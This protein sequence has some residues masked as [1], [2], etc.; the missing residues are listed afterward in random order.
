[1][2]EAGMIEVLVEEMSGCVN[3]KVSAEEKAG[4]VRS[5]GRRLGDLSN[6]QLAKVVDVWVDAQNDKTPAFKLPAVATLADIAKRITIGTRAS[7]ERSGPTPPR[8]EFVEAHRR[9]RL[10]MTALTKSLLPQHDHHQG[11]EGCR[12][13]GPEGD[14]DPIPAVAPSRG[15]ISP[16]FVIAVV[17]VVAVL[18]LFLL[19]QGGEPG[20][21]EVASPAGDAAAPAPAPAAGEDASATSPPPA[22]DAAP[23]GA[24]TAPGTDAA[25]PAEDVAPTTPDA[26]PTPQDD[27]APTTPDAAPGPQDDAAPQDSRSAFLD[28][29]AKEPGTDSPGPAATPTREAPAVRAVPVGTTGRLH[30]VHVSSVKGRE[31][32]GREAARLR[33]AGYPTALRQ[34]EIPDRGTWWRVYLGPYGERGDASTIADRVKAAGLTDYT[35]IHRLLASEVEVGTGQGDR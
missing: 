29:V 32:A 2:A 15:R 12:V 28:A 3:R 21:P 8:P 26:A 11:V 23:P 14:D 27:P 1:M 5:I 30:F 35:Q 17:A 16:I 6:E 24:G 31:A 4:L 25:R 34:V 19:R 7:R 13:C 22:T 33:A 18:G 9:F 10:A 20:L